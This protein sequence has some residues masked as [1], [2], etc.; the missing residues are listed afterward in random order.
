MNFLKEIKTKKIED[1][2]KL[3]GLSTD[4]IKFLEFLQSDFCQE[5]FIENKV[6]I[7]IET[8]NIFFSNLDTNES[9]YGFFQQQENQSKAK[10]NFEFS[11][12]DSYADYFDLLVQAFKGNKDQKY[13]V[14]TNKNSNIYFMD[15]MII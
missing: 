13:D 3:I 2:V 4:S 1:K 9:I 5:I 15:L 6:K 12:T 11:F 8:C 10:I 7:H 14:L